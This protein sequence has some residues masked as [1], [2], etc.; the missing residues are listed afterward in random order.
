LLAFLRQNPSV[1]DANTHPRTTTKYRVSCIRSFY[2]AI[3]PRGK[4][5]NGTAVFIQVTL[6]RRNCVSEKIIEGRYVLSRK[7]LAKWMAIQGRRPKLPHG[8]LEW[9]TDNSAWVQGLA[10]SGA[11][12]C[13]DEFNRIDLEVLSVVA[14]QIRCIQMAV[15][16]QLSSFVFEGTDLQLN[17]ACSVYITMNPGYAGRA[18]LPDNLKSLFRFVIGTLQIEMPGLASS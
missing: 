10:S 13:F 2:E 8:S 14:Q 7:T 15:Q 4:Q 6:A 16:A 17:P 3:N 18:E 1:Y 9:R 11:W 12:A 5:V